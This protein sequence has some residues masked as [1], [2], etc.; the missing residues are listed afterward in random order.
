MSA[1]AASATSMTSP[2]RNR[3]SSHSTRWLSQREKQ[4][5]SSHAPSALLVF[6]DR[7]AKRVGRHTEC[8][9][10]LRPSALGF[11]DADEQI[12]APDTTVNLPAGPAGTATGVG[13]SP[14]PSVSEHARPWR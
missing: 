11:D 9:E 1:V 5:A 2:P 4:N 12:E 8:L 3:G 14:A 10:Q 7:L 6:V 13:G